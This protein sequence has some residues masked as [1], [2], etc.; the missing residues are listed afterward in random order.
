MK[1]KPRRRLKTSLNN[2]VLKERVED[3]IGQ[4]IRH[5]RLRLRLTQGQLVAKGQLRGLEMS[6]GTLAKIE[7]GLQTVKARELFILAIVLGIAPEALK[8]KGLGH[9]PC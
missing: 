2:G 9:P 1:R 7:V 8:P 5:H 4:M 3:G 6:R